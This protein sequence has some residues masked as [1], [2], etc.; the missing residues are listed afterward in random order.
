MPWLVH[1]KVAQVR[2]GADL[3]E[4]TYERRAVFFRHDGDGAVEAEHGEAVV[5]VV[6]VVHV[7]AVAALCCGTAGAGALVLVALSSYDECGETAGYFNH[8]FRFFLDFL[9][10]YGGGYARE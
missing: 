5:Q 9:A 10:L 7:I 6:G 8:R 1:V 3:L 2:R 4:C